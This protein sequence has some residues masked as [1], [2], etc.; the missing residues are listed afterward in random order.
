MPQHLKK[1]TQQKS[2]YHSLCLKVAEFKPVRNVYDDIFLLTRKVPS[3]DAEKTWAVVS[4]VDAEVGQF[5]QKLEVGLQG[6][7]SQDY[8]IKGDLK[9]W[10]LK[11]SH[12]RNML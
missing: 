3:E 6:L 10:K 9:S 1:Q 5:S 7:K 12:C 2:F 8:K 11:W 4:D